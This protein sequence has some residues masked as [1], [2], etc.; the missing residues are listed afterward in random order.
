M[1]RTDYLKR[2][3]NAWSVRVQI[4]KWLRKAAGGKREYVKA[5]GTSDI[6]EAERRKHIH[7]AEFKRRIAQLE[8]H[9][10]DPDAEL[11]ARI[12]DAVRRGAPVT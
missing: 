10:E 6:N 3:H 5:L 9:G 1:G 4:P 12:G 11:F 8:A 2:R 7:V